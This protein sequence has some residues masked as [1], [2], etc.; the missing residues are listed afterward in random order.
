MFEL[1][2][3]IHRLFAPLALLT[4]MALTGACVEEEPQAR[5]FGFVPESLDG[6]EVDGAFHYDRDG[7]FMFDDDAAR[8]FDY[9]L[10][11]EGEVDWPELQSWVE[12]TVVAKV[13][14]AQRDAV[15]ASWHAYVAYRAEA[16]AALEDEGQQGA[17]ADEQAAD[18]KA[19]LLDTL[20]RDFA[21]T[22]FAETERARVERAFALR[23]VYIELGH[24]RVARDA[25]LAQIDA[26]A[27]ARFAGTRAGQFLA[28][29]EQLEAARANGASD[30][31]LAS[32]RSERF[33][34]EA[35]ERLA[36]L[37]ARRAGWNA[38]VDAFEDQREALRADW[39]GDRAGLEAAL[40]QLEAESF[41][42]PERRR[43]HALARVAA[44]R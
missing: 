15:L 39:A 38:R 6:T 43:L 28:A 21:G 41:T 42:A 33:S 36:A 2:P 29:R 14:P 12:S 27:A 5:D 23:A 37:D 20:N 31:E 10:T 32:I 17:Q 22:P 1:R 11:S 24:D 7:Q 25:A 40:A 35:A 4:A 26:D 18:A 16:A 30:A 13:S 3:T 44:A 8:A 9:F 34:P 19:L